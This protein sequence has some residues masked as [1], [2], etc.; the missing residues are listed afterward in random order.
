ML[1]ETCQDGEHPAECQ[2]CCLGQ[3]D[4]VGT[5][6]GAGLGGHSRCWVVKQRGVTTWAELRSAR[7]ALPFLS[8]GKLCNLSCVLRDSTCVHKHTRLAHASTSGIKTVYRNLVCGSRHQQ[9][10]GS[11]EPALKESGI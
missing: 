6:G 8:L 4:V 7:Q 11:T 10:K 1:E 3:R 2:C 9:G 5:E